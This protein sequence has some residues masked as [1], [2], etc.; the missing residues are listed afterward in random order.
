MSDAKKVT[1]R[2]TKTDDKWICPD[3][4][5]YVEQKIKGKQIATVRHCV[6]L[7]SKIAPNVIACN[8]FNARKPKLLQEGW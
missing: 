3:C 2:V 7:K 4:I 1:D 6:L 8:G 5:N